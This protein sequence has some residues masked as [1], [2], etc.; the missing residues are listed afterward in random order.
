MP[1]F[2]P[3]WGKLAVRND[4][5]DRENVG[6]IRSPIRVSILPDHYRKFQ[7]AGLYERLNVQ[8]LPFD[9]ERADV[10]PGMGRDQ[11]VGVAQ[12]E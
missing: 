3:Y 7:L 4:R 5:G 6:I 10:S 12:L 1:A 11:A 9:R 2:Q 8:Q